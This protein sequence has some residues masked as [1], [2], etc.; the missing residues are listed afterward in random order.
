MNKER[1]RSKLLQLRPDLDIRTDQCEIVRVYAG[2]IVVGIDFRAMQ[3]QFRALATRLDTETDFDSG[4]IEEVTA[5]DEPGIVEKVI[6]LL[7]RYSP[8]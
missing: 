7:D 5:E 4:A 3:G 1:I 6:A 8:L 2:K